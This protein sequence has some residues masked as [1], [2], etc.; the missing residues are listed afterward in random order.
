MRRFNGC[1]PSIPMGNSMHE[2]IQSRLC[3]LKILCSVCAA[4]CGLLRIP[5]AQRRAS[6]LHPTIKKKR[7]SANE[8]TTNDLHF[9]CLINLIN[10][11]YRSN[12]ITS[13]STNVIVPNGIILLQDNQSAALLKA[14]QSNIG[15]AALL[16]SSPLIGALASRRPSLSH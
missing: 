15:V 6:D 11:H 14:C 9:I 13:F 10:R 4:R 1:C 16:W 3:C 2:S 5:R 12:L 7:W 8:W